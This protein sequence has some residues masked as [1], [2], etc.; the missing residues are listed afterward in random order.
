LGRWSS[1]DPSGFPD[2][3]NNQ[4]Y[5]PVPTSDF[6]YQGLLKW[7]TLTDTHQ[8][9]TYGTVIWE[10]W[11]VKTDDG[12]HT[13]NLWKYISGNPPGLDY[14]YNCHG[15]TFGNSQYWIN[16]QV[17]EILQGDGYTLITGSD[18]T[19]AKVAYWGG[20]VHTARVNTVIDGT[21]NS[22]T[23]KR[24]AGDLLTSSPAGQGY[25]GTIQDYE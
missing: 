6:D 2:G 25:S 1:A 12:N 22:V 4:C 23:G 20:D 13:I 19:G 16:G 14:S 15:Y 17:G 24:G 11:T 9:A 8:Q 7:S 21:V 3:A 18:K 5:A 10:V